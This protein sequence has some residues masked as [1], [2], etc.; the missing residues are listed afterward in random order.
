MCEMLCLRILTFLVT[1]LALLKILQPLSLASQTNTAP[2]PDWKQSNV[3]TGDY[4][5]SLAIY[6]SPSGPRLHCGFQRLDAIATHE[7]FWLNSTL[8]DHLTDQLR[9]RAISMGR[10]HSMVWLNPS[11][12]VSFDGKTAKFIR[13]GLVEEYATGVNGIR[14]D[15]VVLRKPVGIG[16]LQVCLAVDGAQVAA[17]AD[18]A[19]LTLSGSGRTLAYEHLRVTD[20]NGRNLSARMTAPFG[21]NTTLT[22]LVDDA[23]AA[24]PV[25]IDP[26]FSDAN[27]VGIGKFPAI[28]PN[29]LL[30][31]YA[32][33]VDS[34]GN[35]Y[36]GGHFQFIG[37][38]AATNVA[39]WD[40]TNWTALGNGLNEDVYSLAVSGTTLYAGGAFTRITNSSGTAVTVNSIAKWNGSAWGALGSGIGGTIFCLAVSGSTLYAGGPG[41]FKWNGSTWS[42]LGSLDGSVYALALSGSTLYAGG[43]FSMADTV[44][45]NS[46]AKWN[47]SAWSKL[48][49]GTDGE[50][51]GLA[52]LGGILYAG[53]DFSKAGTATANSLAQW[54]GTAWSSA[55]L[56]SN[57]VVQGLTVS[58]STLYIA[59]AVILPGQSNNSPLATLNAGSFTGF[60]PTNA[61]FDTVALLGTNIIVGGSFESLNGINILSLARWSGTN[62]GYVSPGIDNYVRAFASANGMLYVGGQF[63][64][65][66]G[67][68]AN[69]IVRWDGHNWTTLGS[70]LGDAVTAIAVSGSN[71]Y[72]GGWF[73]NAGSIVAN[74]V[75]RWDGT[76]WHPLG[77]GLNGNVNAL[78]VLGTN[79]FAGGEFNASGNTT[80]DFI[81]R[82]DGVK[83][84]LVG[85]PNDPGTDGEVYALAVMGSSLYMGGNI[86]AVGGISASGIARW[87]GSNWNDVGQGVN[88]PVFTLMVA[89]S[90]LYVGGFFDHAGGA[91]AGNVA[92]WDGAK[93]TALGSGTDDSVFSLSFFGTNVVAGGQFAYCS[94]VK[95]NSIALWDGA[96]WNPV[97]SGTDSIIEALMNYGNDLY[98]GGFFTF[99]AGQVSPYL[100][101]VSLPLPFE[102]VYA[103]APGGQPSG[104]PFSV[105]LTGPAGS[106]AVISVTTNLQNWTPLITNFLSGGSFLFADPSATNFSRRFYRAN[107]K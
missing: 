46:I 26:T 75:A 5:G 105:T 82:W 99:A 81:A 23:A 91:P 36:I 54:N 80:V 103:G 19:R 25:R 67:L 84:N 47:G 15:F 42:S 92:T 96:N 3:E 61:S 29:Y 107:L 70:G 18:A 28:N 68:A 69:R 78:A 98:V 49:T 79:L 50:V 102:F 14:Q 34:S 8:G 94:T 11:G 57:S 59:G 88:G 12:E 44:T 90:L 51:Y 62:W 48:G 33:A 52:L 6:S 17:S 64:T 100:A 63:D 72:A 2:F 40:G 66:N 16:E 106:N 41:V 86:T 93:W 89:K 74:H 58:G 21:S 77:A 87:D 13:P 83:W 76:N 24:Y 104:G 31:V 73:T 27:W 97:G 101:K 53:G 45:A 35:L 1:G 22:L 37:A 39:K 95:V 71:I 10:G 38:V 30:A 43:D 7:G 55:G 9:V 56:L 65:F 32:T 20:A 4:G 85:T 60:A